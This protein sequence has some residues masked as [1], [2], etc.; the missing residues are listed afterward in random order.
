MP[1]LHP[2]EHHVC[3]HLTVILEL[4]PVGRV[5][6][7]FDFFC[8]EVFFKLAILV[9]ALLELGLLIDIGIL[10]IVAVEYLPLLLVHASLTLPLGSLQ[11]AQRLMVLQRL[12]SGPARGAELVTI[13]GSRGI[14]VLLALEALLMQFA[15]SI[16][17]S[18][19]HVALVNLIQ[20]RHTLPHYHRLHHGRD[21]S[22]QITNT[23][24]CLP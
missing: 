21:L 16:Q 6:L 17:T 12:Q 20:V 9:M 10:L 4:V 11:R 2:P 24:P 13:S 19:L 5:V 8:E 18:M 15:T 3:V 7:H 1:L 23:A 22:F 14:K